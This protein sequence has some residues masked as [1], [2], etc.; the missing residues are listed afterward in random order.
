MYIPPFTCGVLLT[1][2]VEVGIAILYSMIK[3]V[4]E[5]KHNGKE[6][7]VSK[8]GNNNKH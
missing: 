4:K 2:I 1:I 3:D 7:R 8:Q 6:N 5:R